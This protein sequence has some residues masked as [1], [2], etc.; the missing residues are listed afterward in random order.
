LKTRYVADVPIRNRLA[1]SVRSG[2]DAKIASHRVFLS[3]STSVYSAITSPP[4]RRERAITWPRRRSLLWP[5]SRLSGRRGSRFARLDDST[6]TP[7]AEPGL[8]GYARVSTDEQTTA[9]Q[10]DALCAV[11]CAVIHQDS[12]SGGSRSRPGLHRALEDLCASD[13]LV[14]WRSVKRCSTAL[15]SVAPVAPATASAAAAD[16]GAFS[17]LAVAVVRQYLG[18]VERGEPTA[19]YAALGAAPGDKRVAL[20]EAGIVDP[21]TRIGRID[22]QPGAGGDVFLTVP[23][24]T[25]SGPYVA[26]YTVRRS[27]SGAAIIVDHAISKG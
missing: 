10:L 24:R 26:T 3:I 27:E 4:A 8:I 17:A 15:P 12:A 22:A 13:T 18:A 20:K 16:A 14:V 21:A 23:L 2:T 5:R 6:V 19:A 7:K 25:A 1:A 9:L 11:G